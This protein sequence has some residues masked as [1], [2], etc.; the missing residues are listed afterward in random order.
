MTEEQVEP[1]APPEEGGSR[2]S[3]RE[4]SAELRQRAEQA[5][6]TLQSRGEALRGRYEGVRVAYRAY[7]SDRRHA[8]A[9]LA[10]GVAYRL[11]IWLI[12]TALVVACAVGLVA[13]ITDAPP[14]EVAETAGLASALAASVA[15]AA[16]QSG[17]ASWFLLLVG[18]WAMVWAGKSAVKALR[19]LS[20]VAWQVRPGPFRR[21][22]LAGAV[23]SGV[24]IG[25]LAIP[26]V[27]RPL[28]GGGVLLDAVVWVLTSVALVPLFVWGLARLPR[29]EGVP[30]TAC[31]PGAVIIVVGLQ[32]LRFVT[33]VYFVGRIDRVGDLYGAIG[34]ATVFM[35][36]LYL[37]GRLVA[38]AMAV[39]A[40]RWRSGDH[41][42]D[43][44]AAAPDPHR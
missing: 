30:W 5:T 25:L 42:E 1:Q 18:G 19:L 8:G 32:L 40:E 41:E 13:D 3:L 23:F 17:S 39:N 11:F 35:V 33:A 27:Q 6:Q 26:V 38:A 37:I 44:R 28:Y 16:E 2:R 34:V 12:P 36:W 14:T 15:Q 7:D 21:S 22:L 24:V 43:P 10:G 9:L 31:V 4:R 29:P 20:G